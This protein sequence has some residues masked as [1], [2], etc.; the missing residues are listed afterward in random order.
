MQYS[1]PQLPE[2]INTS[3]EHPLKDFLILSAGVIGGLFA[4]LTILILLTGYFSE[5]IPFEW[6]SNFP[7]D[8]IIPFEQNADMPDYLRQVSSRV[9]SQMDLPESMQIRVHYVN[10]DLVNAFATLGG[11][12]FLFRGLLEKL[13]S[14]DELAMVI[15]HEAAHI[16]HRHPIMGASHGVVASIFMSI[17]GGSAGDSLTGM[18]LDTSGT[19]AVLR[20]S[21]D[22]EYESD[23][24]ATQV[25]LSLYGHA[26]GANRLFKLFSE[27]L[28]GDVPFEFLSTHPITD[29]R[30][31]QVREMTQSVSSSRTATLTPLP[32]DFITWLDS[33]REKHQQEKDSAK[34]SAQT[35]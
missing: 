14:E 10:D 28:K 21:R 22:F 7:V 1:N 12:V 5:K 16:K 13:Q 27:E 3:Q 9:I 18:L 35:E 19:A 20:F 23:E 17:I 2:G 32:N 4:I 11:H 30:I 24:D 8:K 6:E 29:N 33:Q 26:E 15:A 31:E 25:L 34:K